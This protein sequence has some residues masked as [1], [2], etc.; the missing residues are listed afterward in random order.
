MRTPIKVTTL[1]PGYIESKMNAKVKNKMS[2]ENTLSGC[3]ALVRAIEREPATACVP[4]W[5]WTAIGFP[6]EER[7]ARF[8]RE[9]DLTARCVG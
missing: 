6:S 4:A 1:F 5:P 2:I 7:T 3:C 8:T 9:K